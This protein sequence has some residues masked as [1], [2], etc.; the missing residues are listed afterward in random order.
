MLKLRCLISNMNIAIQHRVLHF[1]CDQTRLN[2]NLLIFFINQGIIE[3][4]QECPFYKYKYII[5][6]NNNELNNKYSLDDSQ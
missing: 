6:L 4:F 5:L 2:K 1:R 3:S